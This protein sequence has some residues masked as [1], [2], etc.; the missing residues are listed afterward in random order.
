MDFFIHLLNMSCIFLLVSVALNLTLGYTGII[1]LGH[2]AF[3][4]VGAYTS[5]LLSVRLGLPFPVTCLGAVVCSGLFGF[6]TV[7]TVKRFSGDTVA[8]GTLSFTFLAVAVFQNWEG[9]TG[10]VFGIAGIPRP[11]LFGFVA[12]SNLLYFCVIAPVTCVVVYGV[13]RLVHSP[14][15]RVLEAIRDDEV[16]AV[17]L[18]KHVSSLRSQVF[19]VSAVVTGLAG[20]F[21]A[22]YIQFIDPYSFYLSDI[23]SV[24]SIVIIGGLASVRGTVTM[25]FV[26][27][28]LLEIFRFVPVPVQMIGPLQVMMYCF[29]LILILLYRPRGLFGKVDLE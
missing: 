3:L 17:A 29:V 2:V 25:A 20:S 8:L 9:L 13:S 21:F 22:H 6:V 4:G 11:S 27:T 18:G 7:Q 12:D 16:G 15:G 28:F 19:V 24:L 1:N 23:I 5:A 14:F 26:I 10:G